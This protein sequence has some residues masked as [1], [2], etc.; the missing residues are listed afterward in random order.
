MYKPFRESQET[1]VSVRTGSVR[2]P[3]HLVVPQGADF[4]VLCVHNSGQWG[5]N[6]RN[7]Y[8][9]HLLRQ[10][11]YATLLIDL[12]TPEE[13]EFDARQGRMRFN[14]DLLATRLASAVDW[15][16]AHAATRSLKLGLFGAGNAANTVLLA[17]A[18]RPQIVDGV[19]A[20]NGPLLSLISLAL[21]HVQ[22][23]TLLI[24]GGDNRE[25][26]ELHRRALVRLAGFKQLAV[27]PESMRPFEESGAIEEVARL[28][29]QWF[30]QIDRQ[31]GSAW[32]DKSQL[33]SSDIP[34]RSLVQI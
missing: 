23:P 28:S 17:A 12:L 4:L 32:L 9:S 14:T 7:H 16:R 13:E 19:V 20:C 24:V 10:A 11:G 2:L 30:Q 18:E 3:G 26:V 34:K 25:A 5:R 21:P 29:H 33:R 22:M 6:P 1:L 15:T 27:I 8:F 31:L